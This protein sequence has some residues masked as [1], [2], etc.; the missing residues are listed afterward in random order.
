[1]ADEAVAQRTGQTAGA[2]RQKR[3][4]LGLPNPTGN[5]WAAESIAL[6]GTL[7]VT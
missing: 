5:R 3:E 1:M 4:E 6:L 2:V 7:L